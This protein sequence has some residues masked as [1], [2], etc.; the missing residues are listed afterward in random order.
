M[1]EFRAHGHREVEKAIKERFCNKLTSGEWAHALPF[2]YVNMR[3]AEG[4]FRAS[5]ICVYYQPNQ[6]SPQHETLNTFWN[7]NYHSV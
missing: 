5:P 1:P 7:I 4:L 6:S 2:G 3:L